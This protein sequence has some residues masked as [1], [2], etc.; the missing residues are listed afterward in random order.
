MTTSKLLIIDDDR[1]FAEGLAEFLE[2]CGHDVDVAF[3]G[4]GGIEMA[5]KDAYDAILIDIGLPGVHGVECLREIRQSDPK[6]RCFMLTGY[7][8]DHI[9][10]LGL[11]A[12]AAEILTK[13]IDPEALSRRFCTVK[14]GI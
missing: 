5:G 9:A 12:G 1:D 14:N 3:T 10:K 7:S 11:E 2:L 4:E 8:A 13:P 6:A